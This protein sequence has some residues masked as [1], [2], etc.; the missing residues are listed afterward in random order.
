MKYFTIIFIFI[1]IF[2]AQKTVS[3][4]SLNTK[5][6][7][8]KFSENHAQ[9]IINEPEN[10]QEIGNHKYFLEFSQKKLNL[11]NTNSL[12]SRLDFIDSKKNKLKFL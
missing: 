9:K 2:L 4:L 6:M 3:L 11:L 8:S 7:K 5:L 10:E 12:N 1:Q